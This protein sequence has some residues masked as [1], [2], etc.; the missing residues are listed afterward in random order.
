MKRTTKK[1]KY[2]RIKE[3]TGSSFGR[4]RPSWHKSEKDYNRK[5]IKENIRKG[6]YEAE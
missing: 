6:N 3:L 2:K 4:I 5:K 1:D